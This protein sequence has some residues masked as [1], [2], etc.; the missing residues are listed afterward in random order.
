MCLSSDFADLSRWRPFEEMGMPRRDICRNYM[1]SL[2]LK[3]MKVGS[4]P[5]FHQIKFYKQPYAN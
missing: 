1:L 3:K 4:H 5:N 2:F